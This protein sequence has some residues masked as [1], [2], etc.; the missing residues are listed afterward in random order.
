MYLEQLRF[1]FHWEV[2]PVRAQPTPGGRKKGWAS[3]RALDITCQRTARQVSEEALVSFL[4]AAS[5]Q[6]GGTTEPSAKH[7][8]QIRPAAVQMGLLTFQT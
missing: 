5:D 4:V 3:E 7:A 6:I 1:L 2:V 8:F